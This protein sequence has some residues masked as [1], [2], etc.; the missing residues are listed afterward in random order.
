M[1]VRASASTATQQETIVP[2]A[3]SQVVITSGALDQVAGSLG[4]VTLEL[5]DT[6]SNPGAVSTSRPDNHTRHDGRR[7]R[8]LRGRIGRRRDRQRGH[9]RR[10]DS[11]TVYYGDTQT[12][13]PTVTARPPSAPR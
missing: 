3:A 1:S 9:R 13:T 12:G 8:V 2:A 4:P 11:A 6:Y 5:E 7:R 10:P